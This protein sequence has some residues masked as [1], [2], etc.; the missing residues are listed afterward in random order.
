LRNLGLPVTGIVAPATAIDFGAQ[1][2]VQDLL[3]G[4]FIIAENQYAFGDTVTLTLTGANTTE[5][6]VEDVSLRATQLRSNDGE[7][8]T[9]PNGQIMKA[10][11]LSKDWARAVAD[12]PVPLGAD[13]SRINDILR[14]AGQQRSSMAG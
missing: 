13:L 10:T 3:A 7:M 5:G 1:R 4:V 11:N 2:L 14:E 8:V 9:V 6:T 12:V